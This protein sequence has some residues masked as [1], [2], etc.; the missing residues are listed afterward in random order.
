MSRASL[1]APEAHGAL[2]DPSRAQAR[3]SVTPKVIVVKVS[4]SADQL[5]GHLHLVDSSPQAP[6]L[7]SSVALPASLGSAPFRPGELPVISWITIDTATRDVITSAASK[8]GIPAELWVRIAA[9]SSRLVI[10]IAGRCGR[11]TTWVRNELAT[12]AESAERGPL[13]IDA[14]AL[15]RY[16]DA[17]E[18]RHAQSRVDVQLPLRLPEE[19]IGVWR[20]EAT[21]RR[22]V[23][24]TW[25]AERLE[26]A[27]EG[28]VGW[29]VA[30]ARACQTL[31]EWAYASSLRAIAASIA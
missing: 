13:S 26:S 24:P 20:R 8:A 12:A 16:A 27:P 10:E 23:L 25:L 14:L 30:A 29:E 15:T 3:E 11:P 31:G 6:A 5:H 2:H 22:T 28:C 21:A 9:E 19:M 7:P 17:L 4:S 1:L 18:A